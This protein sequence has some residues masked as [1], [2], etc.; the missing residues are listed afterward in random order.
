MIYKWLVFFWDYPQT[1]RL[2]R[3]RTHWN[4]DDDND[5]DDDDDDDSFAIILE[6]Y[7]SIYVCNLCHLVEVE[8][9]LC[10]LWIIGIG[11]RVAFEAY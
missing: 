2:G 9:V 7:F 6:G 4:D 10:C 3:T 8:Y 5:D 1:L 11:L